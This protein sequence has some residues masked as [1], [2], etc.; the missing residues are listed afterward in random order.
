[1]LEDCLVIYFANNNSSLKDFFLHKYFPWQV[2]FHANH[3]LWII[4]ERKE[5]VCVAS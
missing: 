2:T 3:Q 5:N 4:G 1:M